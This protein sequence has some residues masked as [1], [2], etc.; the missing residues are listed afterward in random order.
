MDF[1]SAD[2]ILDFAIQKEEEAA[3]F[4]TE[5]ADKMEKENMRKVF[6]GFAKEELG[7]K[8]KLLA[9]KEGKKL[10]LPEKKIED[11]KIADYLVEVEPSGDL[12]YQ[13]A[14]ILAMKQEKAAFKLYNNLAD[15]TDDDNLKV[16]FLTLAQEEARHKLRFEVEYDEVILK[17]N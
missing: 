3:L 9:V 14:L 12:D 2:K 11:L 16:L 4:Y 15:K 8:I 17:E 5:L 6:E 10:V 7:H 13:K 1:G